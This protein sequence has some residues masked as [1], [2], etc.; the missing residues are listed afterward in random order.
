MKKISILL[1]LLLSASLLYF[2]PKITERIEIKKIELTNRQTLSKILEEKKKPTTDEM[3]ETFYLEVPF[4]CQAPLETEK[5]WTLHEESCEEAAVLQAYLYET[6]RTLTKNL[7]NDEILKMIDWEI[8]NLGSHHDLYSLELK[9]F[10]TSYFKLKN[11]EVKIIN[12]ASIDDL[13]SEVW[14]GHPVIVPITGNIL[15]N[16]Y[17][18]YPGYHMLVV[19]GYTK[20]KIVTNDNGT[21]RGANFSYEIEIFEKAY[22][23]AGGDILIF[24]LEKY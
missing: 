13:K 14:K 22:K 9:K 21:R 7:A 10:I 20:D 16:P 12:D 24:E 18:P 6:N 4:I 19:I 15:K 5:N 2:L 8:K 1:L 11:S 17:Y 23:D 3:P